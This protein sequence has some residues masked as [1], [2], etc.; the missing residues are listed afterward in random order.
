MPCEVAG[1]RL[2]LGKDYV[3]LITCDIICQGNT[4]DEVVNQYV[5]RVA[6]NAD[7]IDF[8]L[9]YQDAVH[10][11]TE[12]FI[13]K[14]RL[15]NRTVMKPFWET[16]YGFAFMKYKRPECYRCRFKG[17]SMADITI[18]DCWG[19]NKKYPCYSKAGTSVILGNTD[20]GVDFIRSL[21]NMELW[22]ADADILKG[23]RGY[24]TVMKADSDRTKFKELFMRENLHTAVENMRSKSIKHKIW[25]I[26]PWCV[27][28]G[29]LKRGKPVIPYND[30]KEWRKIE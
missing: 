15:E 28:K 13:L 3:N 11:D 19:I 7:V 26:V 5:G 30:E 23:N 4:T 9:R 8:S 25:N 1:L 2:Y 22:K 6:G 20:K 17:G 18:G 21:D 27:K 12:N 29:I 14:L 10:R 24:S 16:D